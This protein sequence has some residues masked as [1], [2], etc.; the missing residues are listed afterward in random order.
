MACGASVDVPA[1]IVDYDADNGV[2]PS[3]AQL[4]YDSL[5]GLDAADKERATVSGDHYGHR[6][7]DRAGVTGQ[8]PRHAMVG[9]IREWLQQRSWL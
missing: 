5:E 2:F 3:D 9:H 4:I 1:L 7:E 6:G 8:D